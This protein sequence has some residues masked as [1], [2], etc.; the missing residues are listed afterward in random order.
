MKWKMRTNSLFPGDV[1]WKFD[2]DIDDAKYWHLV[3]KIESI[4]E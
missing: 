4:E 3:Y 2:L 1:V